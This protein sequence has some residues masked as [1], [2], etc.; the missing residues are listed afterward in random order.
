VRPVDERVETLEHGGLEF[1]PPF[2][3]NRSTRFPRLTSH[4]TLFGALPEGS[5]GREMGGLL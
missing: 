5:S 4:L 2:P 1:E 3:Y